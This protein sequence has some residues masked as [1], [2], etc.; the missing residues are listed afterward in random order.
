MQ[1]LYKTVSFKIQAVIALV[2]FVILASLVL[3]NTSRQED[4]ISLQ[5]EKFRTEQVATIISG[6]HAI[7]ISGSGTIAEEYSER[8]KLV[9]GVENFAILNPKG[10]EAF[11]SNEMVEEVNQ[12]LGA[13]QFESI[14]DE[15]PVRIINPDSPYLR[16]VLNDSKMISYY[17]QGS[18]SE[19]VLTFL[20][21][22]PSDSE[23]QIC[24]GEGEEILGLVKLSTSLASA[25]QYL[26]ETRRNSIMGALVGFVLLMV[27]T[28]IFIR[29]TITAPLNQVTKAMKFSGGTNLTNE[30]RAPACGQDEL[31]ERSQE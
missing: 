23:C 6:L 26:Q 13:E 11:R 24:H 10:M 8:L 20:A 15:S 25:K 16:R 2:S 17:E 27:L 29:K 3:F 7:M 31:G 21:P 30:A 14:H 18:N 1:A 9:E 22:I 12:R 28:Q 4:S 19:E 5:N